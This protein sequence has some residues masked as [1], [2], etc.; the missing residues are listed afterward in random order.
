MQVSTLPSRAGL[1]PAA[2]ALLLSALYAGA[3]FGQVAPALERSAV[4]LGHKAPSAPM[5]GTV[6]LPLHNKAALDAAVQDM[7]TAGSADYHKF[8][9][10]EALR[11][12][13]PTAEEM[14]SVKKELAAHNLSIVDADAHNF[15]VK[16]QGNTSDF[17]AA[18]HTTVNQFRT[19]NGEVVGALA[20]APTLT[21]GAAGMVKAVTGM[22]TKGMQPYILRPVDPQTGKAIGQVPFPKS[23]QPAGAFYS[24][25][26][27]YG[28]ETHS[29]IN[30]GVQAAYQ[31]LRY[32]ANVSNTTPG[33]VSPCGYSPQDVYR[34][35]GLNTVYGQ[36][37]TGKG[38]T[39]VIVDAYGSPTIEAD[40]AAFDSLYH[41]PKPN[42]KVLTPAP[43]TKTDTG[44]AGETTLDVEWAHA[45]APDANIVLIAAPTNNNDDLQAALLYAVENQLGSVISNS[46]G[47]GE[48]E[49]D[50]QS[51]TAYDEICELASFLGISTQFSSGDSGDM[52]A[53]EMGQVDV[54]SP[55][56]SPYATAVGGTSDVF[57]P[58][59]GSVVQIG[60][61]NNIT[62]LS[63]KTKIDDPP[64]HRG[65][66]AGA[67]GGTSVYFK[68][69]AYQSALSG[70]GRQVPDVS[71][72]ADPYTPAEFV[73]T[74]TDGNQY[75]ESVGGTS[76][77][78]P[79]F[80]AEW[81]L[82]NQRFG[83]SLGQAAPLIA[84]V[85]GTPYIADVVPPP[86]Q[87]NVLG[88]IA[89]AKGITLYSAE[90]LAAPETN[91]PFLSALYIGT[92]SGSTYDLSFGTDSSLPVTKGW[93]PVTGFGSLNM[94]AIFSPSAGK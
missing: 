26:C 56:S 90:T 27:F 14:A 61:G 44:W 51:L 92:V 43:V 52:A 21:G 42:F 6:W 49:S 65:F 78:S 38:Q 45:I 31:G 25:Q 10:S 86:T 28:V 33:T 40:L 84:Q 85:A 37:Y 13:A 9:G 50:P 20:T 11:Q 58:V 64:Q 54:S 81:A 77:A 53:D 57:S 47:L 16:V 94:G 72:L 19:R 93:D 55:A 8:A 15:S 2:A 5:S 1:R 35:Y 70:T 36:G 7:Y 46:Y 91:S 66:Y 4:N 73:F 3:A 82:L 76:L 23:S 48:L 32:G 63:T 67:G 12:F 17:E 79:I 59:D 22:S 71:A 83:A 88:G 74:E 87:F 62:R 68:K 41:L 34:L 24:A 60:W 89:D 75:I 80:S 18:F 39:I 29:F 69:P 30:A